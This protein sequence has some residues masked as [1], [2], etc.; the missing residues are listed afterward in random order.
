MF[1][2]L[3]LKVGQVV[4]TSALEGSEMSVFTLRFLNTLTSAH[5]EV[6]PWLVLATA[7]RRHEC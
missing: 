6:T 1:P 7:G 5:E 4:R 2:P 3:L